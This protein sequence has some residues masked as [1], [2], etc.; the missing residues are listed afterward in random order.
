MVLACVRILILGMSLMCGVSAPLCRSVLGV[1]QYVALFW[2]MCP[3]VCP[4]C[5]P[6]VYRTFDHFSS[7]RQQRF[8]GL[9]RGCHVTETSQSG[10]VLKGRACRHDKEQKGE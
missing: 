7:S 5:V 9:L 2:P 1:V 10:P 3:L 8:S 4:G 6:N